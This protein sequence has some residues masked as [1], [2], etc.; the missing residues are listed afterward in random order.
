MPE[1][2]ADFRGLGLASFRICG[3][4]VGER[5]QQPLVQERQFTQALSQ[6]IEVIFGYGQDA[7]VRQEVNFGS[8]FLSC[9]RFFQLAGGNRPDIRTPGDRLARLAPGSR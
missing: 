1:C 5:D 2:G 4:F 8:A 6:G 3:A 7:L 9:A